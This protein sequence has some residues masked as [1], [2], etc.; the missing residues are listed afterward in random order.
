MPSTVDYSADGVAVVASG[1]SGSGDRAATSSASQPLASGQRRHHPLIEHASDFAINS[2]FLLQA[3]AV[4]RQ[5]T[6]TSLQ[7]TLMKRVRRHIGQLT[8]TQIL[9]SSSTDELLNLDHK[10][11]KITVR[12]LEQCHALALRIGAKWAEVLQREGYFDHATILLDCIQSESFVEWDQCDDETEKEAPPA[13]IFPLAAINSLR[14]YPRE[15]D[16]Q[17]RP[18]SYLPALDCPKNKRVSGNQLIERMDDLARTGQSDWHYGWDAIDEAARINRSR[19]DYKR[20]QMADHLG[21][22]EDDEGDANERG[23]KKRRRGWQKSVKFRDEE[24]DDDLSSEGRRQGRS[25]TD[26]LESILKNGDQKSDPVRCDDDFADDAP[27][28]MTW[29]EL[30]QSRGRQASAVEEE[31]ICW[32]TAK[33]GFSQDEK[34]NLV[35]SFIHPPHS[36]ED[37]EGES[38]Q[39]PD[40]HM[41]AAEERFGGTI[42]GGLKPIAMAH[43][44]EKARQSASANQA[45]ESQG[46]SEG[47]QVQDSNL[48]RKRKRDLSRATKERL[49]RRTFIKIQ[50]HLSKFFKHTKLKWTEVEDRNLID[51]DLGE[52][53]IELDESNRPGAGG[54]SEE[55]NDDSEET[56]MPRLHQDGKKTMA[57]RSLEV[58]LTT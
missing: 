10:V 12:D 16:E 39:L 13:A 37:V 34:R 52:C 30:G 11:M 19:I 31:S 43:L 27:G 58:C 47:S 2:A 1:R 49:G 51:F 42:C 23:K 45:N 3:R 40:Q 28:S 22:T 17:N 8:H 9:G 18:A 14:R 38:S 55:S 4:L 53:T 29:S 41:D 32:D 54:Q 48:A 6:L 5:A 56:K 24:S 50:P 35:A 44:W 7:Q 36:F 57:F 15:Y 26:Q 33:S 21:V 20:V 25:A 46:M